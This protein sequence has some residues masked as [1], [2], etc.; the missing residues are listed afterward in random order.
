MGIGAGKNGQDSAFNLPPVKNSVNFANQPIA[1]TTSGVISKG[2]AEGGQ[3]IFK[4]ELTADLSDLQQN[5]T[6][7]LRT[8]L[9]KDYRCLLYTSRCV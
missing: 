8:E 3:N 6:E 4:L 2:A 9:D 1:I 5:I 7:V